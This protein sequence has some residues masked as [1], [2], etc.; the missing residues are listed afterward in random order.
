MSNDLAYG[1]VLGTQGF[2]QLFAGEAPILTDAAPVGTAGKAVLS[3]AVG[4]AGTGYTSAP[5]VAFAAAPTGGV[6]ATGHAVLSGGGVGSIV[7]D[8]PGAGYVTA[9]G[10]TMTGGAGTGAAATATL[11]AAA[12]SL[13]FQ[14]Y[15]VASINAGGS[16]IKAASGDSLQ[17]VVLAQP[18]FADTDS[19]PYYY[20][21]CFNHEALIWPAGVT[22]LAQ[23]KALFAGTQINVSFIVK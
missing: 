9:P 22:T 19:A 2:F 6:T 4:T 10:I 14:K 21:A 5:A 7:I 12:T 20:G 3:V 16:L 15:E 13:I 11:T 17:H 18:T 1:G 23:R 8:N